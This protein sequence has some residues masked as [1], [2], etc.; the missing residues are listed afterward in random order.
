[1]ADEPHVG[2][3]VGSNAGSVTG[4]AHQPANAGN[5]VNVTVPE[6]HAPTHDDDSDDQHLRTI[7][8]IGDL[9]GRLERKIDAEAAERRAGHSEL[10]GQIADL[11]RIVENTNTAVTQA[12]TLPPNYPLLFTLAMTLLF[13][14]VVTYY[15]DFKVLWDIHWQVAYAVAILCYGLSGALWWYL[16]FGHRS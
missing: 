8:L 14:P 9:V 10:S 15:H 4:T 7:R 6:A 3:N 2:Q 13:V 5:V 11:R 1:M 12:I 16:F